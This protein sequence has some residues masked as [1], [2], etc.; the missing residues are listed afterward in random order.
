MRC[1]APAA[2]RPA[3]PPWPGCPTLSPA[4]S[5]SPWPSPTSTTPRAPAPAGLPILTT[6]LDHTTY[7]ARQIAQ[8]YAQ[9]WQAEVVYLRIKVTLR[10]AGTRLRGQTPELA[11]QEIWGLLI[12]YN[13]LCDLAVQAAV[14]VG[15]DPDAISFTA[16]LTLTR[17]HFSAGAP[18]RNCGH[19]PTDDAVEALVTAIAAHPRDR[20]ARQR[21]SPR[22]NA[23]QRTEHTRDVNYTITM[24]ASNLPKVE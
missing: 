4:W 23:Q 5:S 11:R 13:A 9:R 19:Q 20:T 14:S 12:V 1:C 18:C 22:V 15:V 24:A 7:P 2:A 16:V 6:L 3:T 10:G 21:T 8:A 17:T